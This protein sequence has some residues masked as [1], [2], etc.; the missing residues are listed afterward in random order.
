MIKPIIVP[1][2]EKITEFNVLDYHE[3]LSHGGPEVT[4]RE[5][6]LT[7][8]IIGGRRKI[9]KCI[10]ACP[11]RHHKYQ[12]LIEEKQMEAKMPIEKGSIG[13]FDRIALDYA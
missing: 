8:W 6:K 13:N 1:A 2:N 12:N 11:N 7:Y 9:R 4:L 3:K 10:K 5:V